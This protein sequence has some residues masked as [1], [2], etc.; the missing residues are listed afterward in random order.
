MFPNVKSKNNEWGFHS[1]SFLPI[2]TSEM[3]RNKGV[4][5]QQIEGLS[6]YIQL[7]GLFLPSRTDKDQADPLALVWAGNE[8][9]AQGSELSWWVLHLLYLSSY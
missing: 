1:Y 8:A 5:Q 3:G 4:C 2:K 9:N 7:P 6:G